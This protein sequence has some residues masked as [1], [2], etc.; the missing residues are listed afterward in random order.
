M[1]YRVNGAERESHETGS[2]RTCAPRQLC[3]VASALLL[4][5]TWSTHVFADPLAQVTVRWEAP[6]ECPDRVALDKEL[7]RDLEGSQA[8]SLRLVVRAH[9]ERLKAETWR[10]SIA[11]ESNDGKSD[12]AI[13]A[14]SCQALLD[15][16]SLIVAMLI[17]PETAAT[18]A[19][20][21]EGTTTA[22][23]GAP[24]A[25]ASEPAAPANTSPPPAPPLASTPVRN[26]LPSEAQNQN[27]PMNHSG[28]RNSTR[29]VSRMRAY[30]LL[31]AWAAIDD[32]SLPSVTEAFGGSLGLLYG[33]WR[34][35]TTFGGWLSRNHRDPQSSYNGDFSKIAGSARVCLAALTAARFSLGPCAGAELARVSG[36][37]NAP[38]TRT[39]RP[40]VASAQAAAL[41]TVAI[42]EALAVRL[43]LDVSFPLKRPTFG[44]TYQQVDRT[45]FRPDWA[46]LLV[47][48]GIEWRFR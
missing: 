16:T 20:P 6:E 41:G 21:I 10:V 9:V 32:G 24:V 29:T 45:L 13:T 38:L 42:T 30:G 31:G 18:H 7:R 43:D 8:P 28:L 47:S 44:F 46:A 25:D 36:I 19:R 22:V 40:P 48:A 26:P 12:R 39:Q 34:G 37:G 5:T 35:E 14:H 2:A 4:I 23:P 33:P 1:L 15:A 17:D 27:Q 11:T 3:S